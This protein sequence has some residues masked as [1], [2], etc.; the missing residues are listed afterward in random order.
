MHT[1]LPLSSGLLLLLTFCSV[2]GRLSADVI[3][4]KDGARL[5]G[6]ISAIAAGSVTLDTA[7]AGKI[8][9][10]QAE[11]TTLTTD[12]PVSVRL[13]SGTRVQGRLTATASGLQIAAAEGSVA[14]TLGQVA[15]LW[16]ADGRDPEL[17][18]LDR[19]WVIEAT[20][21]AVGRTG[22]REQLGTTA[23][24]RA[25]L[26]GARDT[27]VLYTAY[28]RQ[29][30]D[31]AKSA[32]QLKAGIDYSAKFTARNSW[33]VRTEGGFDR[34][35]DIQFYNLTA[36]GLGHSFIENDRQ[37][38]TGRVGLSYRTENYRNP[39]NPDLSSPGGDL[40]IDHSLKFSNSSMVNRLSYL[41][42]FDNFSN[43]RISHE[44]FLEMP[45]TA[46]RWKIRMGVTNEYNSQP[47][48]GVERLDTGYFT[49]LVLT[50][51]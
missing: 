28:D 1:K 26:A 40:G 12:G 38:L 51:K 46:A 17:V 33:Y 44:S 21:D 20:V 42:S 2:V 39:L 43:Y 14:T 22:T 25:T 7:Y 45:L 3:E 50:W 23:G 31:G 35:K 16:A 41:P 8:T 15:A 48:A 27:L 34:I 24:L 29:I 4:T 10:K 37:K 6:K 11:V 49:R 19:K 30:T 9:V 5:V 13:T 36:A 32:D 18:E 47:A